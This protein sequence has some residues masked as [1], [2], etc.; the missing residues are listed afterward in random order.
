VTHTRASC[1]AKEDLLR[2]DRIGLDGSWDFFFAGH[3]SSLPAAGTGWRRA[4]VPQPWQAEFA[5]LRMASGT[6]WYRRFV[7]VPSSWNGDRLILRFGAV[8][9]HAQV[10]VN[11]ELAGEHEGSWLP[12][13]FDVAPFVRFGGRNEIL[14]RVTL[15]CDDPELYPDYPLGEVPF[16]RQSSFG[17]L[18]GIWQSVALERR[19]RLHMTSLRVF[20]WPED[21]R[22]GVR[23]ALNEPV[24]G[25]VE[26]ALRI[27]GTCNELVCAGTMTVPL[28]ATFAEAELRVRRPALWSPDQ[29]NLYRLSAVL[30]RPGGTKESDRLVE[31]FGFRTIEAQGGRLYLNGEPI[32][33]RGALD[34]DYYPDGL[35]T[36]PSLDFLEDQ[37]LKARQLGLNC[38]RCHMKVP[39]PRYFEVAD[40]L[41][42][43]IWSELPN[44]GRLTPQSRARAEATLRGIIERDGNH[45]SIICWTI[46]NENCGTDL[47]HDADHRAWIRK[48]YTW[49]RACDPSRLAVDTSPVAPSRHLPTED[50]HGDAAVPHQ[51]GEWDRLRDSFAAEPAWTFSG[52]GVARRRS[53]QEP[54]MI[55]AFGSAGLPDPERLA[56]AD[57]REPWWFET[58]HDGCDGVMYPHGI[59]SRFADWHLDRVFGSLGHLIEATQQQ[60]YLALKY[61]IESI[62]R[63]P[64]PAGY[65]L[66]GFTDCHWQ[67]NGLLDMRRNPRVFQ[68][69]FPLINADTV[70]VPTWRRLAWW[71]GETLTLGLAVAH[72]AGPALRGCYLRACLDG[73]AVECPL[74]DTAAGEVVDIGEIAIRVPE[75]GLPRSRTVLLTLHAATGEM[76]AANQLPLSIHPRRTPALGRPAVWPIGTALAERLSA[77]GYPLAREMAAADL[78]V[79]TEQASCVFDHT[80]RGGRLLL[81]ADAPM[82][83]DRLFPSWQNVQVTPRAGTVWRGDRTSSFSWIRRQGP[84]AALPGPVLLDHAFDRVIPRHVV[85]GCNRLDFEARVHAGVFVGWLHKPAALIAERAYGQ[86]RLL[87]ST[88]RLLQDAPGVDPTATVLLDSLIALSVAEERRRPKDETPQ[89]G[90]QARRVA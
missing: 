59:A 35:A 56:D 32:Y 70:I 57:G 15:P 61:Q 65:V 71:E 88:F 69:V 22:V 85:T 18:G 79:A 68:D 37:L 63:K 16:G 10:R 17:P 51:R 78:V 12:F 74:P 58:G 5:D 26:L 46:V 25:P 50:C 36:P 82:T 28:G 34:H 53:G 83:L 11:G 23:V 27:E 54:L 19:A 44:G 90:E 2:R 24:S 75:T 8:S 43:L 6:G 45:P 13:E 81:L 87:V 52:M 67:S 21:G 31:M 3:A 14:V 86:G 55:S 47:V 39:D 7:S 41:G 60:Q 89:L 40:R 42:M 29:P 77:A 62:R 33:L 48:I 30:R 20:P 49:L 80:Q 1:L 72:G 66:T 9:Y 84:L 73:V 64:Q 38:L 4:L 76:L